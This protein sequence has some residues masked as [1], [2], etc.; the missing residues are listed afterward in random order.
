VAVRGVLQERSTCGERR[1]HVTP[2]M[3]YYLRLYSTTDTV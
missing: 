3:Y 1:R 2:A